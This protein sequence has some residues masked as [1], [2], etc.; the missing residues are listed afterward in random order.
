M[1]ID[2]LITRRDA[3]LDAA[4]KRFDSRLAR[5]LD[6]LKGDVLAE[7]RGDPS[8]PNIGQLVRRAAMKR[9][10]DS[11]VADYVAEYADSDPGVLREIFRELGV[12]FDWS[13]QDRKI[14]A[15]LAARDEANLDSIA[16]ELAV[17]MGQRARLAAG[18]SSLGELAE[19]IGA[20]SDKA[21][22]HAYTLAE[23]GAG[24]YFATLSDRKYNQAG[25]DRF[26][27]DGP[28]DKLIRPFC[29]Q[30][31]GKVYTRPQIARMSNGQIPNVMVSRGGFNCRHQWIPEVQ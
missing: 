14:A 6:G 4:L 23:T 2:S 30:R 9:G 12:K 5:I 17:A 15:G 29:R 7:L 27:Y 21:A 19:L 31:I 28:R 8:A 22:A 18:T 16:D 3:G 13:A 10:Y 25:I 20:T 24:Q 26:R 11:L 1:S